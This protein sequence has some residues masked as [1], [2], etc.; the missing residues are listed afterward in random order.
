[1]ADYLSNLKNLLGIKEDSTSPMTQYSPAELR[2][3]SDPSTLVG[4]LLNTPKSDEMEYK[5]VASSSMQYPNIASNKPY[6]NNEEG[7]S[8]SR[9]YPDQ[10]GS[11]ATMAFG[12][13][14]NRSIDP[15]AANDE[16]RKMISDSILDRAKKGGY[17]QSDDPN[18]VK[19]LRI[20]NMLRKENNLSEDDAPISFERPK[21][22]K[23]GEYVPSDNKVSLYTDPS[24]L[25][26]LSTIAHE[27]HHVKDFKSDPERARVTPGHFI[28]SN[29]MGSESNPESGRVDDIRTEALKRLSQ[30]G[31]IK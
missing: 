6:R 10:D 19:S 4:R 8:F 20:I 18:F 31:K 1:M 14:L 5:D 12:K 28:S 22:G 17:V 7:I 16:A 24:S 21:E 27:L 23:Y 3:M 15:D 2:E 26:D 11:R 30:M 13:E 29:R 9:G 25:S